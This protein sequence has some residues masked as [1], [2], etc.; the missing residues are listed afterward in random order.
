MRLTEA[1]FNGINNGAKTF[2]IRLL[3][4]K[5]QAIKVGDQIALVHADDPSRKI[6]VVVVGLQTA[7]SFLELFNKV[8]VVQAGWPIGTT[9]EQAAHDMATYYPP[10]EQ[11][12]H[13]VVAIEIEKI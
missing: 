4:E 5:R 6:E 3:D 8:E 2:E 1:N 12:E 13:Q 9:L 11:A 10:E 7:P